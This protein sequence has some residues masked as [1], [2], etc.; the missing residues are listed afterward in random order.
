VTR[1]CRAP[2]RSLARSASAG[3]A[4]RATRAAAELKRV[5]V[6]NL[7]LGLALEGLEAV[8]YFITNTKK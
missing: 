4:L 1:C 5:M 6:D 2:D 3:G 8:E 7:S